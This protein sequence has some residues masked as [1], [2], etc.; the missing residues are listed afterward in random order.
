MHPRGF[1]RRTFN[2]FDGTPIGYQVLEGRSGARP[3]LLVNGL[4]TDLRAFGPL[5]TQLG[6]DF[7][8]YAI[9][10][11]GTFSSGRPIRGDYSISAHAR[12]VRGLIQHE[13]LGRP[14]ALGWS[15]GVTVLLEATRGETIK[16]PALFARQVWIN[17]SAGR[18]YSTAL[19]TAVPGDLAATALPA[20]V[21]L[22][23]RHGQRSVERSVRVLAR[24]PRLQTLAARLGWLHPDVDK[25][26]LSEVMEAFAACDPEVL[27]KLLDALA[28]HDAHDLLAEVASPVL[29]VAGTADRF[30]P[31]RGATAHHRCTP[32]RR[33]RAHRGRDALRGPRKARV[34]RAPRAGVS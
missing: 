15:M 2:A 17:G 9:D 21:K 31:P 4:G 1:Q 30:V 29:V 20:L 28:S 26:L 24:A 27:T 25:T 33:A 18:L 19:S 22:V 11:R 14:L 3:V 6:D 10:Q 32:G 7:A 34:D 13:G 12:D 16:E 23:R 8:Y 5:V